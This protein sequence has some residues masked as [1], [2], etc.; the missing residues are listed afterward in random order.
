MCG[1]GCRIASGDNMHLW[2]ETSDLYFSKSPLPHDPML[3]PENVSEVAP[4]DVL[5]AA[6]SATFSLLPL[7]WLSF[8]GSNFPAKLQE[9]LE[10][11]ADGRE[12]GNVAV[13]PGQDDILSVKGA[14]RAAARVNHQL[15]LQELVS[16]I[17]VRSF[18]S[19]LQTLISHVFSM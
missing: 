3:L 6:R 2:L 8:F 16:A 9:V 10:C 4:E 13:T 7:G 1:A 17:S 5:W 18:S 14:E 19:D 11:M 15:V 12:G